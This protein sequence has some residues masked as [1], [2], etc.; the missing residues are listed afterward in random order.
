MKVRRKNCTTTVMGTV[1]QVSSKGLDFPTMI[2]V[3]YQ[4]DGKYHEVTESIT[5]KSKIIKL[6]FLPVGQRKIPVMGDTAV[7]SAAL[8]N[9]NP[10]NP[11]EAYITKNVG[12]MNA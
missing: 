5:L 9:Y 2:T 7:G 4:V 8:V 11:A 1:K 10:N 6:G 12:R 3:R